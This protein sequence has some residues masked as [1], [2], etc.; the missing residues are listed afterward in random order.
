MSPLKLWGPTKWPH[1]SYCRFTNRP[2]RFH[3]T[4]NHA[5]KSSAK[6]EPVTV[7]GGTSSQ[8]SAGFVS[9]IAFGWIQQRWPTW[10]HY[11][12]QLRNLRSRLRFYQL[13]RDKNQ[14]E[15]GS[16]CSVVYS[17]WGH[18]HSFRSTGSTHEKRACWT[19]GEY[20]CIA[21][22]AAAEN[23]GRPS[24]PLHSTIRVS[25]L[26]AAHTDLSQSIYFPIS[27]LCI[28]KYAPKGA[29]QG[30]RH[31]ATVDNSKICTQSELKTS[32][33]IYWDNLV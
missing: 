27:V 8:H 3:V 7:N 26:H 24:S 13:K 18:S 11:P 30:V 23:G 4:N 14:T 25:P 2:G 19:G 29:T 6:T 20:S 15:S 22:K 33:S 1:Y 28:C 21:L 31:L 10:F 17:N 16:S 12:K 32:S 9:L 5:E